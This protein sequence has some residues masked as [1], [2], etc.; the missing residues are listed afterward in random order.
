M[1]DSSN[2]AGSFFWTKVVGDYDYKRLCMPRLNPWKKENQEPL[3]FYGPDANLSV[4]F[5]MMLGFQHSLAVVGGT[6]IPGILL[7]NLDP[8]GDA[9]PY[10]VSYALITSGICTC[11]QV[12]HTPIPKTGYFVGSG[13]LCV[14][15]TSFAF[16]PTALQ[17][18]TVQMDEGKSFD[19][20]YGSLIG[21]FLVGAIFQ[22]G[23]SFIPGPMLRRIFPKWL[24]GLCVFLV[25]LSLTG[26][27]VQS[28]GGGGDCAGDLSANCTQVGK[29]QLPFGSGEYVGLGF[30]VMTVIVIFELFGSPFLRS[31]GIA[32]ALLLG[33]L[34]AAITEDRNGDPYTDSAAVKDAPA[35]LF[36]WVKTFPIGFYTPAFL[37][38]LIAYIVSTVETYGDTS[39]T[40]E[41]SGLQ[42]NNDE[43]GKKYDE[44]IQGGLIGDAVNSFIS[45]LSMVLP[46]TTLSQNIGII[47]LTNVASKDAGYACG[48]WMVIYGVFG[49]F[50]A[51]FTSIPQPV[52]G[53]MSTFL[54]ANIAVSGIKVMTAYGID[55][56]ARFIM[57]IAASFGIGTIIV[58]AWFTSGNFLDCPAI[59]DPGLRGACDAVIITLSTG[60]AVGCLVALFLNAVLPYEADELHEVGDHLLKEDI[61]KISEDQE[62][63]E[64]DSGGEEELKEF[65]EESA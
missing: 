25:G 1:A 57:A 24:A 54:F 11:I 64:K 17:S 36:L 38:T 15:A 49:K 63:V 50:G 6:I 40:A 21:V 43:T 14:I 33:Y 35:V 31:C 58:P 20:A 45:A 51:F 8:S 28:W 53:G 34:L 55:R 18:I 39:A 42:P 30:F 23:I 62:D 56:R 12:R 22:A 26:V 10:L 19:E 59:D 7:G 60:Y 9:G 16:L 44:T 29:S 41:A 4:L 46:S 2:D 48:L 27:G 13:M 61:E 37:P 3:P 52:L 65:A 32:I 5:A 47:S